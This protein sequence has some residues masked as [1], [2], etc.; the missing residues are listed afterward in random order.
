MVLLTSLFRY[1]ARF[2]AWQSR[3]AG[4]VP[5]R[6]RGA[7]RGNPQPFP[8]AGASSLR[9]QCQPRQSAYGA[10]H[11]QPRLGASFWRGTGAAERFG[12]KGT[13]DTSRAVDQFASRFVGEGYP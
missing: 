9:G 2:P 5:R 10:G 12:V 1:A 7:R 11:G 3:S 8:A 13:S 4:E 6:R